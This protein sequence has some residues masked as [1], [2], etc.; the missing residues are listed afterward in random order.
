MGRDLWQV[1][2]YWGCDMR[3][4]IHVYGDEM[5]H[6]D[7]D[8]GYRVPKIVSAI[9]SS[10]D[11]AIQAAELIGGH[12]IMYPCLSGGA[13]W[14]SRISVGSWGDI[15]VSGHGMDIEQFPNHSVLQ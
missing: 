15:C 3:I 14:M 8:E 9:V 4:S 6:S 5:A 7:S 13:C 2:V 12:C 11:E 1:T 10:I